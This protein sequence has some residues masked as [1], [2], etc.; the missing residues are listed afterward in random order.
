MIKKMS[1]IYQFWEE[2]D[3]DTQVENSFG[4]PNRAITC[5]WAVYDGVFQVDLLSVFFAPKQSLDGRIFNYGVSFNKDST[6]LC[7]HY[8]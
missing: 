1:C 4:W 5:S 2:G 8:K 7:N 6:S 3:Y